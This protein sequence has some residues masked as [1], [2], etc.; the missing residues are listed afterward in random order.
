LR[1]VL[2]ENEQLFGLT[3]FIIDDGDNIYAGSRYQSQIWKIDQIND[4]KITTL[5]DYNSEIVV[6]GPA[7]LVLGLDQ[8]LYFS[9]DAISAEPKN[10]SLLP[11][12]PCV[13]T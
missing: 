1:I 12:I 6:D 3:S 8:R 7:Q 5:A 13:S 2:V 4:Y 11:G 10:E 9:N